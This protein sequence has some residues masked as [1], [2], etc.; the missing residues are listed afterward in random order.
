MPERY[1]KYQIRIKC[2]VFAGLGERSGQAEAP[3]EFEEGRTYY[4][5]RLLGERHNQQGGAHP[6]KLA[7][8]HFPV[9]CNAVAQKQVDPRTERLAAARPELRSLVP[10]PLTHLEC[11]VIT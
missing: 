9:F 5:K 1:S 3:P 7:M 10:Q 6:E 8:V 2:S 11:R 4:A